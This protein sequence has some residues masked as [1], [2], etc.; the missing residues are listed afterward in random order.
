MRL[1][2][3]KCALL[4]LG[5]RQQT[6]TTAEMLGVQEVDVMKDLGVIVDRNLKFS[7]HVS[8]KSKAASRVANMIFRAFRTKTSVEP[9]IKAFVSFVRPIIEYASPVWSPYLVGDVNAIEHVQR[10]FTRQVFYR[11]GLP[12]LDYFSRLRILK[13][14]TLE[15]RRVVTDQCL[16]HDLIHRN[17][18]ILPHFFIIQDRV[19]RGHPYRLTIPDFIPRTES[20][21]GHFA[22]R[23]SR[24][25]NRLPGTVVA[26]ENRLAFKKAL[27]SLQRTVL[28]ENS[29]IR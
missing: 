6:S 17:Q 4:T 27:L 25:W 24:V 11:C 21:R 13:L 1:A 12:R 8:K 29:K 3:D 14:D 5:Y 10:K 7:T 19:T 23:A 18:D 22:W 9:Y 16:I 26:I 28:V 20:V 15:S 2:K